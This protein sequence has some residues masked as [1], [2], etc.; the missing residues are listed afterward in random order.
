MQYLF[1]CRHLDISSDLLFRRVALLTFRIQSFSVRKE[2][3]FLTAV[4][5]GGGCG[6][7]GPSGVKILLFVL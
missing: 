2:V 6:D 7:N 3:T 1:S 5:V 4:V